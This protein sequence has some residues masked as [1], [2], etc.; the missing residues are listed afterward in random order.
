MKENYN[1]I[2]KINKTIMKE[3]RKKKR[4]WKKSL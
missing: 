3:K 1:K 4:I 2:M